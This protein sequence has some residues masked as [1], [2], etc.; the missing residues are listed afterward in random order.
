MK[1]LTSFPPSEVEIEE[2]E[3]K[4]RTSA[5]TTIKQK[6]KDFKLSSLD[7]QRCELSPYNNSFLKS[8]KPSHLQS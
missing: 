2:R 4:H 7:C 8:A 1:Q 6:G 3:V 5:Y